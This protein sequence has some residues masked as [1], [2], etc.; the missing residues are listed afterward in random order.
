[1]TAVRAQGMPAVLGVYQGIDAS[2]SGKQAAALKKYATRVF[3]T[4]FGTDIKVVDMD[5]GIA[6]VRALATVKPKPL[7]WRSV[8]PYLVASAAN[9]GPVD[10]ATGTATLKVCGYLRGRPFNV[11]RLV[12]IAGV[13]TF[14][15]DKVT[16]E[17]DPFPAPR[18]TLKGVGALATKDCAFAGDALVAANLAAREDTRVRYDCVLCGVTGA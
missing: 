18:A 7:R 17:A 14:Q 4:E 8:R 2:A 12:H 11:N 3:H 10:P 1:M 15:V 5:N 13:G 16:S 9:V 6:L